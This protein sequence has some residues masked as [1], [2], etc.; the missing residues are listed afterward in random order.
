MDYPSDADEL[1]HEPH[2]LLMNWLR[3]QVAGFSGVA[4]A[5]VGTD[6]RGRDAVLVTLGERPDVPRVDS[7]MESLLGADIAP[8]L[9]FDSE[10]LEI[11]ATSRKAAKIFEF[12]LDEGGYSLADLFAPDELERLGRRL[13]VEPDDWANGDDWMMLTRT[14]KEIT[15]HNWYAPNPKGRHRLLISLPTIDS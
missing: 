8:M 5:E 2:F 11:S 15:V 7:P 4:A 3:D 1:P 12:D 14:G 9:V 6:D 13:A 10:T